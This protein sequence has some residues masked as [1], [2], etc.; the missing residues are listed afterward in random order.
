MSVLP[1]DIIQEVKEQFKNLKNEVKIITFS[2]K[3]GC[4]YCKENN[5]MAEEVASTSDKIKFESYDIDKDKEKV[6]QYK[7]D[8]VPAL[9]IEGKKDYGIRFY[10]IPSGYEFGS[11]I[12][13]IKMV[14][15][16][17]SELTDDT[18]NKIKKI[19]KPVHIQVFI[20]PTCP[21]CPRAVILGHKLAFENEFI[22]AD[23]VEAIEFPELSQKYDVQAVPK[24]V[25][26]DEVEFEGALPE[27]MYVDNLMK[28]N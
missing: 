24:I 14:S 26:N 25:I 27:Q 4:Q 13:D 21:Y 12:E 3:S 18:K 19:K 6:E 10:G 22:V 11:I 16:E 7:I 23:M 20:T 15:E 1:E 8:K 17:E 28:I 5:Q 9:V 2:Q